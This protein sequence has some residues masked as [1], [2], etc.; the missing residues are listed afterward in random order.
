MDIDLNSKPIIEH[1]N[2]ESGAVDGCCQFCRIPDLIIE[3]IS[4]TYI[5]INCPIHG[6]IGFAIRKSS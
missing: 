1:V 3:V 4:P 5:K 2:W 6:N